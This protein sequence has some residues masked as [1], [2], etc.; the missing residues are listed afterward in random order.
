MIHFLNSHSEQEKNIIKL[1][2]NSSSATYFQDWTCGDMA[3]KGFDHW[4]AEYYHSGT[5]GWGI[6][7]DTARVE[8]GE[9]TRQEGIR[10]IKQVTEE[11]R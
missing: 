5:T 9:M 3:S 11:S 8:I 10:R 1:S 2:G 6:M 7:S 4:Q